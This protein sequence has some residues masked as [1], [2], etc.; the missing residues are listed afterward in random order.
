[1]VRRLA[2]V[3]ALV[4]IPLVGVVG[5]AHAGMQRRDGACQQYL[6]FGR[7]ARFVS[8]DPR[9]VVHFDSHGIPVVRTDSF[10]TAGTYYNPVTITQWGLQR[11]SWWCMNRNPTNLR[12]ATRMADWLVHAQGAD[13]TWRYNYPFQA[14]PVTLAP[15]WTS[16]LAQGQA[17]SLLERIYHVTG[18]RRYLRAA[19]AALGQFFR[20]FPAGVR[21]TWNGHHWYEEY[22]G[23]NA[24]HVLN[25]FEFALLGL[26]D[27]R[28]SPAAQL[29]FRDGLRS[30][31]WAI[32]LFD[33]GAQGTSYGYHVGIA[34]DGYLVWHILLT[35]ELYRISNE[36]ILKYYADRWEKVLH[37]HGLALP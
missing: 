2:P 21:S 5:S 13:G 30:L 24:V 22:P 1:L 19:R 9:A 3:L 6:A 14:W 23:Y 7:V 36:P 16:A 33:L 25:G 15:G 17:V 4:A 12:D 31:V 26:H 8:H 10:G 29:L 11:Y 20:H 32:P 18:R 37:E 28:E 34:P 27:L 35:R